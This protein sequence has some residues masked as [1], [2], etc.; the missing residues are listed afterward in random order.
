MLVELL[1][2]LEKRVL[3]V[4]QGESGQLGKLAQL[5]GL[6]LPEVAVIEVLMGQR[7]LL[8]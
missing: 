7:D 1:E 6:V 5:E 4:Q 3:L 8:D 2:E